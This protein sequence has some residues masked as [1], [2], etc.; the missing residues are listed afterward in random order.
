MD[1]EGGGDF[2]GAFRERAAPKVPPRRGRRGLAEADDTQGDAPE[3]TVKKTAVWG[4]DSGPAAVAQ[5]AMGRRASNK[6]LVTETQAVD[7]PAATR[8]DDDDDIP[9]I[10]DLEEHD[11]DDIT[12]TVAEPGSIMNSVL[13]TNLKL[14]TGSLPPP[15]VMRGWW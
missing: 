2:E 1:D 12:M 13:P 9:V 6:Q 11:E 10:P 3:P 15:Q 14:D 4:D 5:P 8:V 7:A